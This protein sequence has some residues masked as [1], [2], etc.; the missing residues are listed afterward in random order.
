MNS[1]W[2]KNSG[3][4]LNLFGFQGLYQDSKAKLVYNWALHFDS[5][6]GRCALE[7]IL[8]NC[9]IALCAS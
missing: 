4:V 2:I 7:L 9:L 6:D 3:A 1:R 5:G 8:L